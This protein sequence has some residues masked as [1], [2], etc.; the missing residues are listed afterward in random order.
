MITMAALLMKKKLIQP[1][2]SE[3]YLRII[4]PLP[5]SLLYP[6][7]PFSRFP[8]PPLLP[9]LPSLLPYAPP[10]PLSFKSY[11]T[12]PFPPSMSPPLPSPHSIASPPAYD[13][14]KVLYTVQEL[15][16]ER[17]IDRFHTS[18]VFKVLYLP[19]SFLSHTYA[20]SSL[21]T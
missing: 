9:P 2:T 5:P 16:R 13:L 10:L 18:S 19:R 17:L 7:P 1:L 20:H 8:T 12:F 14:A 11:C 6:L 4:Y 21:Y 15:A 3:S